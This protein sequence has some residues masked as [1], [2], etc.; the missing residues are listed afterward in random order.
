MKRFRVLF[1]PV[2]MTVALIIYMKGLAAGINQVSIDNIQSSAGTTG[3]LGLLLSNQDLVASG[4]VW[5][6]YDS[7]NGFDI[8]GLE[9][10]S[11]TNGFSTGFSKDASNPAQVKVHFLFYNLS[12]TSIAAGNGSILGMVFNLTADASGMTP[13]YLEKVLLSNLSAEPLPVDQLNDGS[14]TVASAATFTPSR[15]NTPTA[16]STTRTATFTPSRTSTP[17]ATSTTRTATF[18]PSLTY[19]PTVTS[20]T[21]T[22]TFT[23]SLTYTPTVTS[24]TRTATFTP[25]RTYT[26][27]VT[28]SVY[29]LTVNKP[30]AG[31]GSVT[32][33]PMGIDCGFTCSASFAAN[34]AVTLTAFTSNGSTFD[35]WGGACSGTGT[36]SVSMTAAQYVTATFTL[37]TYNL[38]VTKVGSGA[39]TVTS[40][41]GG[42]N[43]GS[44]CVYSFNY[45]T[46]ITLTAAHAE[47]SIFAGWLGAGCSGTTGICVVTIIDTTYLTA[48]FNLGPPYHI[49]YL[50]VLYKD[51]Q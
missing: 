35:G 29:T 31:S 2:V 4:E 10:T 11:R 16:T 18:T 27:T 1:I 37:R 45:G 14:V 23:P 30:G 20:T 46:P 5:L 12:G 6:S 21:R 41:P 50:P 28:P 17:T 9:L 34:T 42:I 51:Y 3:S 13:V 32:S 24:T 15:T 48:T 44:T 39:G 36:C 25:S 22:A 19:T 8:T 26:R 49:F 40:V 43:C 38:I 33:S 47:G 7:G